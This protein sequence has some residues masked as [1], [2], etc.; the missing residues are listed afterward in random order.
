[1]IETMELLD[2]SDSELMGTPE[3]LGRASPPPRMGPEW[4][5]YSGRPR[6]FLWPRVIGPFCSVIWRSLVSML[7]LVFVVLTSEVVPEVVAFRDLFTVVCSSIVGDP[8][9]YVSLP[10]ELEANL[11]ACREYG[12]TTML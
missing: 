6:R 12:L 10:A 8:L 1:V 5:K 9:C 11:L 4:P 7:K 2:V 3:G